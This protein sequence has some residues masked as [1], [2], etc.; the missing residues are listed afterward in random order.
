MQ[1]QKVKV[2]MPTFEKKKLILASSSIYR[3]NLLARFHIP[4]EVVT[5]TINENPRISES[6]RKMAMRLSIEKAISVSN[7]YPESLVIAADQVLSTNNLP[8]G[9]PI[10]PFHA[11][12][13]LLALSGKKAVFHTA[14]TVTNGKKLRRKSI[15][16][17]C[18]FRMLDPNLISVYLQL[19]NP[20]N[21]AGSIKVEGLGIALLESIRSKDPSAV[22]GLPLLT[23]ARMMRFFNMDPI[24][25]A[26][27]INSNY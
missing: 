27:S 8:I 5:P 3:R 6:P 7:R 2:K 23:V 1:N 15:P 4:F 16:T 18:K 10:D 12:K 22:I 14:V 9:K 21:A 13:Q 19:E 26:Y 11:K 20:Y 24:L 17:Y 25:S